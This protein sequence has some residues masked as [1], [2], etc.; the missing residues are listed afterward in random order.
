M[1][2]NEI[3]QIV[4]FS[5]FFGVALAALGEKGHFLA[6]GIE[7]LAD[8]MLQGH[9]LRDDVRAGRG[10]RGDR[11]DDHHAGHRRP[12][13]PTASSWSS[14]TSAS[15]C[16]GRLLMG[17]GFLMLG[18][19]GIKRLFNL[20]KEPFLLAFSTASSEAAYPKMLTNLEQFGVPNRITSFVLPMGY[21]FNLDGSM[22][23]CTFAVMFI[24]QAYN[25]ALTLGPAAHDAAPADGDLEGHGRR[26]ARLAGGDLGD[27]DAVQHPGSR[28]A[29]DHRHRPVPRHG[30]LGHQ[31]ARQQRRH[32]RRSPS[33][34]AS[35]PRPTSASTTSAPWPRRPS[36]HRPSRLAGSDRAGRDASGAARSRRL[37]RGCWRS[38][39]RA[40]PP[41]RSTCSPA[42]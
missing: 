39:A 31:R 6:E 20:I 13:S 16:S 36:R 10:V 33:G 7:G 22:M 23:Y 8:V 5:I 2:N 28:A 1:A 14:S 34:R 3:L 37:A 17:V 9:R 15:A 32:R 19:G 42:R 38:A 26:A 30:P 25:I 41:V 12:A 21:S 40:R 18:G 24:A 4:V 27:A 29:A 35:S 11:G